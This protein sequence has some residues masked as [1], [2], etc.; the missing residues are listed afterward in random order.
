M[1]LFQTTRRIHGYN[2]S[3]L[4]PGQWIS[5][6]DGSR[7]QYLGTTRAGSVVVR[8]QQSDGPKFAK[9]DAQANKPLRAFAKRYGA[10]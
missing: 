6:D 3:G 5:L 10:K 4:K 8:W 1:S 2:F 9:R 7:G